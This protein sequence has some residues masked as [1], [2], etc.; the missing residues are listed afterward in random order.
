ME[1]S[2]IIGYIAGS[3]VIITPIPQLYKIINTKSSKDISI[4]MYLLLFVAQILFTIYGVLKKD[5]IIIIT[6]VSNV[7]IIS[8]ILIFSLYYS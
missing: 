2:L 6:N 4:V 8:L 5:I 7:I 3:L 1:L